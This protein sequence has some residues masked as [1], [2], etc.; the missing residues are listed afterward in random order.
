MVKIGNL[1]VGGGRIALMGIVNVTPDSFSD[2]GRFFNAADAISHAICLIDDGA[3]ILDIGGES[4]RPGAAPVSVQEELDRVIPVIK[5]IRKRSSVAISID[6]MKA[7]VAQKALEAGANMINDVSAGRFDATMLP[8]AAQ[9]GVPVCLM[10]M[11]GNPR[12]MQNDTIYADII[13]D[14]C[15]F[16]K[17]TALRALHLGIEPDNIILDP[18]IG[19]GKSAEGNIE[20]LRN[21]Q[22]FKNLKYNLLIGASNKSFIGK[23]LGLNVN[24]RL[25]ATLAAIPACVESGV[26][27]VRLHDVRAAKRFL[28]MYSI[29]SI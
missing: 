9:E 29:I 15:E 22:R 26:D 6:T 20:I 18:G 28:D 5:E 27:I 4:T 23:L 25:E 8:L 10:H 14:I 17:E 2:G 16:L 12:D 21:L 19:F 13:G 24:Q 3:D 1:T 11:R 7:A